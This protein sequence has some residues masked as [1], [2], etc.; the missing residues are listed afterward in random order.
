MTRLDFTRHTFAN[1]LRIVLHRR[2]D[3]PIICLTVAYNVGSKDEAP[4]RTG[5]A[6][7]FEHLMFD[8][9]AHV[10]RGAF[11]KYC[12]LAGG[13][14]NAYTHE[15]KT[16]YYT[17]LPSHQLELGLWLESDRLMSLNLTEE[18]FETQRSVVMEEKLQRVDNQPYGTWDTR[19]SELLYPGHP[20]GHPVIG[21]MDDLAAA[22]M[23]DVTDFHRSYYRPDNAALVLAGDFD[24]DK[25]LTLLESYF[26]P[27]APGGAVLRPAN[28][29]IISAGDIRETHSD[30]VPLP[31]VFIGRRIP[32]EN[33]DDFLALDVLS[34]LLGSGETSRLH[35][36]LVYDQQIAGQASAYV[37]ARRY[38]GLFVVYA[39]ATPGTRADH[40]EEA[41]ENELH[42]LIEHEISARELDKARNRIESLYMQHLQSL[43]LCADRLAHYALFD[44]NPDL[45][46]SNLEKYLAVTA[47]D[48]HRAAQ[49]Y[50]GSG[51]RV[52]LHYIPDGSGDPGTEAVLD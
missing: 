52:V 38:P 42:R 18:G 48:V 22:T 31:G 24:P 17:V 11:D 4:G 13:H 49:R 35:H 50:L 6:H 5:F 46:N 27:I 33:N 51:N 20:Y 36:A 16:V 47:A 28:N 29:T 12:E 19:M 40:L 43:N 21:S 26:A 3:M 25:A 44:D 1:G 14:N 15:D 41:I 8:G 39:T 10:P 2:C 34:D 30:A 7:L 9:S 32:D 45:I 23:D 37:D